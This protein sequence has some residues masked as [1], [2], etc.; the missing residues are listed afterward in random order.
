MST[1]GTVNVAA[2]AVVALLLVVAIAERMLPLRAIE[3][4][5]WEWTMR[6]ARR[7]PTLDQ[8]SWWQI[9]TVGGFG[10]VLGYQLGAEI[11]P[12]DETVSAL[13][14][15][16]V[17]MALRLAAGVR[18]VRLPVALDN[19]TT[20]VMFAV[21]SA[22]NDSELSANIYAAAWLRNKRVSGR[23][24]RGP[25][26]L[27]LMWRRLRRRAYIPL[28]FLV[29]ALLVVATGPSAGV[30][31]QSSLIFAWAV[32]ASSVWRATR[33]GVSGEM[34]WRVLFLGVVT[35][36]GTAILSLSWRPDVL[37]AFTVLVVV[38]VVWCA[39]VRGRPRGNDDFSVIETGLGIAVPMGTVLHLFS[40]AMAVIPAF[41][42]ASLV[43]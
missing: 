6:P 37:V 30:T 18:R 41:L 39:V 29:V 32:M 42:A 16:I 5:V 27:T 40:G 12:L 13:V 3:R 8:F 14:T 22:L 43:G 38:A 11:L 21:S 19:G 28:L 33:L 4:D 36:L 9:A 10:A 35:V 24:I 20:R 26:P 23:R 31:V 25:V 17:A 7:F 1:F 34:P 15:G 2:A